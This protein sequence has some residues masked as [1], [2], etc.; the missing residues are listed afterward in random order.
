MAK[1]WIV[2]Y[3]KGKSRPMTKTEALGYLRIFDDAL[4]IEKVSGWF[5]RT[6]FKGEVM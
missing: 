5:R 4:S 2:H 1:R 6:I 3:S